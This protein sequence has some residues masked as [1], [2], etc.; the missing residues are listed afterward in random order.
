VQEVQFEQPLQSLQS[1]LFPPFIEPV[2]DLRDK[3]GV[4]ID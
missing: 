2:D 1:V 3:E 4:A